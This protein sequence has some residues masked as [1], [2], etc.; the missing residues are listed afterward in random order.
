MPQS[1]RNQKYAEA[2]SWGN[3]PELADRIAELINSGVKTTTSSLLWSQQKH[4]W[5]LEEPRDKS[6]VL[7]SHKNP[8]CIVEIEQV[9]I[10]PFDDVDEEFVYNY[11][12]GEGFL[13]MTWP[14]GYG[15]SRGVSHNIQMR[16]NISE[17]DAS[18]PT[19]L[20]NLVSFYL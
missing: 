7:D 8:V 9:Y 14:I 12:E 19:E 20:Q 13:I 1:Q 4:K 5:R 15:Y 16:Y 10:K 6:T 3:A 17:R 11:G 2:S 18:R